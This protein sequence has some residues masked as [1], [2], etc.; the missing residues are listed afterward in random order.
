VGFG[1]MSL[2]ELAKDTGLSLNL[3]QLAQKR[4]HDEPFRIKEGNRQSILKAIKGEGLRCIEGGRYLHLTGDTDKG[5]ATEVLKSLY[6]QM[7]GE[8]KTLAV[9]NGPND[10]PML[11]V[12]DKPFFIK[13]ACV[14]SMF[15][16]W[17]GIIQNV[18]EGIII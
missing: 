13:K 3:A 14:N 4:E 2:H 11:R 12:V 6:T 1:D 7:F 15:N 17:T 5:K 16:A 8:I 9:G 10:L 18:A